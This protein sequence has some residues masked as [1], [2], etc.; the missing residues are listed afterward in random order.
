MSSRGERVSGESVRTIVL[1]YF[2]R[3]PLGCVL[4]LAAC[5]GASTTAREPGAVANASTHLVP[6]A[7]IAWNA[8]EHRF[9]AAGLPAVARGGELAIVAVSGGDG[10]RGYPNVHVEIR[11]RADQLVRAISVVDANDWERLAPDGTPGT[12]LD[13]RIA[14]VN[15]TLAELHDRHGLVAARPLT[16]DDHV[17]RG[18]GITVDWTNAKL[19]V[20]QRFAD[21][22]MSRQ[23]AFSQL[24]V[25]DGQAWLA[26]PDR[27][28]TNP[29]FLRAAYHAATIHLV[30]V[31]IAYRGTDTC[32]EPADQWHVVAW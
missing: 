14:E 31:D 27:D 32:W 16:V 6:T 2:G 9:V 11:D 24:A 5:S 13:H 26:R 19:E 3:A 1:T 28:C 7:S 15:R 8:E 18:N 17:A 12:E 22:P 10:G 4:T 20:W 23:D 25:V 30:V 21:R 29:A